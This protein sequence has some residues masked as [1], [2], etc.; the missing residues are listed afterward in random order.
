M[1]RELTGTW[2]Y[3]VATTAATMTIPAGAI[4]TQIVIHSTAGGTLQIFGGA[5]IT[6]IASATTPTI[7]RFL[8]GLAQSQ[9]NT[10]TSGSQ[11][12]VFTGTDSVF[13]EWVKAGN[14]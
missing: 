13:V 10:T 1:Y 12:I 4:V 14:T 6:L 9:N 7:L 5:S 8:H 3:S 2:G 11:N